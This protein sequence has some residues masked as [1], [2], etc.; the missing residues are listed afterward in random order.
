MV[1]SIVQKR[2]GRCLSLQ[3]ANPVVDCHG[4]VPFFG[5]Q[6]GRNDCIW[7]PIWW[8]RLKELSSV[9]NK[10][11]LCHL[12]WTKSIC[13][14]SSKHHVKIENSENYQHR[15]E[16]VISPR[17]TGTVQ[18]RIIGQYRHQY[19]LCHLLG[20]WRVP[21]KWRIVNFMAIQ[22]IK[23]M[24]SSKTDGNVTKIEIS[25]IEA[26]NMYTVLESRW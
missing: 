7:Y 25:N 17:G 26:Y 5:D 13:P 4:Y 11:R 3:V 21:S 10:T 8:P 20:R 16:G 6:F 15:K 1:T 2:K 19:V 14:A 24:S 22:K 9:F 12:F 23:I 18:D